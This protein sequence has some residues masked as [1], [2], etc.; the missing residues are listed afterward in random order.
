MKETIKTRLCSGCSSDIP[1]GTHH[2]SKCNDCYN[3]VAV[4]KY[5]ALIKSDP[6]KVKKYREREKE[7]VRAQRVSVLTHYCGGLKPFCVCCGES[8]IKFLCIDHI[9]GGGNKHRREIFGT[10]R[11]GNLSIWL[12][13]NKFPEGY[14]ILCHNC[15]M[16]KGAYGECPHRRK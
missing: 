13:N 7:R 11:S 12:F 14:Q 5:H 8:E 2:G 3:K 10:S 15:N 1:V 9:N 16:A 6:E 4:E